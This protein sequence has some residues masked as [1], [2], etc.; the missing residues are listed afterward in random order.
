[1]L[2][3]IAMTTLLAPLSSALWQSIARAGE[4]DSESLFQQLDANQDG[5]IASDEIPAAKER[6][7]KR[8]VR[9]ADANHDGSLDQGEFVAGLKSPLPDRASETQAEQARGAMAFDTEQFF[10]RLDS[11]GDGRVVAEEIPAERR[12]GFAKMLER[13]DTNSDGGLSRD[14]FDRVRRFLGDRKTEGAGTEKSAEP[15]DARPNPARFWQRLLAGDKNS[16]GKLSEEEAPER[17]QRNFERFDEN[18]DGLIDEAEF[19][20]TVARMKGALGKK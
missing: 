12:E 16:D 10:R 6:L 4:A 5:R 13:G 18:K 2:A 3:A 19:Q 15:S 11:N 14:E 20:V 8:L 17:M 9:K 7:W 1:M